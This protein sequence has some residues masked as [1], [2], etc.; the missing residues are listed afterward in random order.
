MAAP[1][2]DVEFVVPVLN[3]ERE[4]PDALDSLSCWLS[5]RGFRA[6]AR[7]V[8]RGSSDC[9]PDIVMDWDD[10]WLPLQ[11]IGCSRPGFLAAARRGV[12]TSSAQVVAIWDLAADPEAQLISDQALA[13]VRDGV[14]VTVAGRAGTID[15]LPAASISVDLFPRWGAGRPGTGMVICTRATATRLLLE[16]GTMPQRGPA[17]LSGLISR[18]AQWGKRSAS[19]PMALVMQEA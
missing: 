19:P 4:L 12:S 18:A 6:G 9:T 15:V 10:P 14:I 16:E 1:E 8:D 2:V 5:E 11:L 17:Y 3:A 13:A 7:V